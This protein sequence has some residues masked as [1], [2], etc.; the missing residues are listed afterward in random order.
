MIIV[1]PF[2]HSDYSDDVCVL[3]AIGTAA[4]IN[5]QF[6][7][8]SVEGSRNASITPRDHDNRDILKD[9]KQMN[10][11]KPA[12]DNDNDTETNNAAQIPSGCHLCHIPHSKLTLP[13]NGKMKKCAVCSKSKVPE[14]LI[15]TIEIPENLQIYG[16]G[17]LIHAQACRYKKDLK[18]E[19][20]A[21]EISDALPFLEYDLQRLLVNKLKAKGMNAIFGMKISISIGEKMMALIGT[22]TGVYLPALPP[23]SIPKIVQ[24][25][26]DLRPSI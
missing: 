19:S 14:V 22:G 26:K 24:G 25:I 3:S 16:R 1:F 2:S 13:V 6:T 7:M 21:K 23:P 5:Q 8:S 11:Q 9:F 12:V 20:N 17:C 4:L 10:S 18:S 15:T